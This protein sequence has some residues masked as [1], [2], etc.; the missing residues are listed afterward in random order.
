MGRFQ[1]NDVTAALRAHTSDV[2]FSNFNFSQLAM[3]G[4]LY[5]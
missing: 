1:R 5:L 3:K 2:T 4:S